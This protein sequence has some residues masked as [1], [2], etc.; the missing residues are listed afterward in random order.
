MMLRHAALDQFRLKSDFWVQWA[1]QD[2]AYLRKHFSSDHAVEELKALEEGL[3]L[4]KALEQKCRQLA[5]MQAARVK[6]Q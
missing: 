2:Q 5:N 3:R 4:V 6:G 1:E